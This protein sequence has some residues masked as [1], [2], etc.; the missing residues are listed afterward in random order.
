[1]N[2]L[3]VLAFLS[4][5]NWLISG[6]LGQRV[7]NK[8]DGWRETTHLCLGSC[9]LQYTSQMKV[10]TMVMLAHLS[11]QAYCWHSIYL[12]LFLFFRAAYVA[13][14]GSQARGWIATAA[15]DLYHSHS[16]LGS[17][18]CLLPTPQ[19]TTTPDPWPTEWVQGSNLR[20]RGC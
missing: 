7:E 6:S 1:M 4:G 19:L 15:A 2:D 14:R 18:L 16:N 12:L 10:C 3:C 8:A 20:P 17:K 9:F 13:F 11:S 5:I